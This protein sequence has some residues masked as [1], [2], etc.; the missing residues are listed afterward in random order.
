VEFN[1][2]VNDKMHKD[3]M[4]DFTARRT[5]FMSLSL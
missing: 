2:L 5:I 3:D 1:F 4:A